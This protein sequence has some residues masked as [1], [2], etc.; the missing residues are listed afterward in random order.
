MSRPV[1]V[2]GIAG[3]SGSG[4]STIVQRLLEGPLADQICH[5][6]HDAYY[7]DLSLLPRLSCGAGN[8]DHPQALDNDLFIEHLDLLL[9]G[10]SIQQ[11][12]YDFAT[13]CRMTSVTEIHPRPI[14]LVEGILLL[15]I[16]EIRDRLGLKVFVDTPPDLRLLRRTLRDI[17]ERGRSLDSVAA[18]YQLTVRP[19]HEQFVEPS[20]QHADVLI[21]W[22]NENPAALQLLTARL[23]AAI[24]L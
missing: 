22:V 15:A 23:Q 21:P 5:L 11:P 19:M 12:I 6:C 9:S 1:I 4:K 17:N 20:R 8:W 7:K 24:Q 3:G 16:P 13:H 18:Q 10:K 14:L 2:P